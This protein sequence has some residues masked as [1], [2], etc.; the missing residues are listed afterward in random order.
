MRKLIWL[1]A[2]L[3]S[4]GLSS[5]IDILDEITLNDDK[6][7]SVFIGIE[8]QLLGSIME[9]AKEQVGKKTTESLEEFPNKSKD[10][11]KNIKGISAVKSFNQIKEGRIGISFNFDNPKALNLAYYTLLEI[12][13]SWYSPNIVKISNHKISRRNLTKQIID[14]VNQENPEIKNSE[15]LKYFTL[16]TII[17]LPNESSSVKYGDDAVLTNGKKIVIRY[18]FTEVLNK[19]YSTAYKIK[20]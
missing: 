9:A 14:Q 3:L 1:F 19:E 12:K 20:F 15:Y 11:I 5:C 6:S 2:L 8:S 18:T 10:K 7:G 13:K 4:L 16:K 17:R